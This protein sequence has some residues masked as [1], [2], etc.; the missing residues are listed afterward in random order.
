MAPDVRYLVRGP[1]SEPVDPL[2]VGHVGTGVRAGPEATAALG[3]ELGAAEA[4]RAAALFGHRFELLRAT[5]PDAVA[6]VREAQRMIDRDG[7]F[8][9]IGE[10]DEAVCT[11]LA[12]LAQRKAVLFINTDCE[13]DALRGAYC[14]RTTF[15]VAASAAMRRDA[16][17]LAPA[18]MN[19]RRPVLWYPALESF[20]AA[21]LNE[22]FRTAFN[23]PMNSA[24]W[25]GWIAVKIL[26][27]AELRAETTD[28]ARLVGYL[29]S[30]RARFDGHKGRPLTF[31]P[32]SHQLR[33]PLYLVPA[34]GGAAGASAV[35]AEVPRAGRGDPRPSSEILDTLGAE[36]A[37]AVCGSASSSA[38]T[39]AP[40]P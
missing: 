34:N 5:V 39:A 24:A 3:A 30:G 33:Q 6:A 27:E 18:G 1:R 35:I 8:A 14:R 16:L 20:G 32:W 21:Q 12:E 38:P 7:V 40:N 19:D 28:A 15:H 11:A 9:V 10:G 22:R 25:A 26:W 2:R 37:D 36:P 17:E 4:Q 29:E 13:A 23:R 31:R